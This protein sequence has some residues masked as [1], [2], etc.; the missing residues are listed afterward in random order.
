[1]AIQGN[2]RSVPFKMGLIANTP[3]VV[4]ITGAAYNGTNELRF[5]DA[6]GIMQSLGKG[7]SVNTLDMDVTGAITP[8]NVRKY[9]TTHAGKIRLINY[10][11]TDTTQLSNKIKIED[12]DIYEQSGNFVFDVAADQR[13]TQF[14]DKLQTIYVDTKNVFW[15]N[16]SGWLLKSVLGGELVAAAV[17]TTITVEFESWF[18]YRDLLDS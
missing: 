4:T 16:T 14:S 11:S 8:E 5:E 9:L 12:Q 6:C 7:T 3:R 10:S 15:T 2:N 1:M 17:T 18:G 13:N